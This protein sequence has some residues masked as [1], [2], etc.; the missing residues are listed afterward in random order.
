MRPMRGYFLE[1]ARNGYYHHYD[2]LHE[3]ARK[4]EETHL[5]VKALE[6]DL[7]YD[8]PFLRPALA[9]ITSTARNLVLGAYHGNMTAA[10]RKLGL[11]LG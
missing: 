2:K 3:C 8:G 7:L 5:R 6:D 4:A 10:Y 1:K 11:I 9:I